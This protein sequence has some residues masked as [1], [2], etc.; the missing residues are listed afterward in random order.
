MS[1]VKEFGMSTRILVA[2][3]LV[4]LMGL[5]SFVRAEEQK[6]VTLNGTL[7][8]AKCSLKEGSTC[9]DVLQ[10]KD[11]DK[12]TSYYLADNEL[13]KASHP[14]ICHGPKGDVSV[15]GTVS[16]KDGKQW[17][18]ASKVEGLPEKTD[19]KTK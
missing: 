18:T 3:L 9:Q 5:F 1:H 6:E 17:I 2:T 7:T 15:T 12:M 19:A 16:E 8:C 14:A 4:A 10:V 13:A 11:G